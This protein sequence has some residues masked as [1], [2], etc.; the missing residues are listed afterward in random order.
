M[1]ASSFK[2]AMSDVSREFRHPKAIVAARDLDRQQKVALLKQWEYD[3]RQLM[4][5]SEESMTGDT[6]GLT[7]ELLRAVRASLADLGG[8]EDEAQGTPAKAGGD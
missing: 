6:P 5:A 2:K 7:A 8:G 1:Q 4:V 3:L